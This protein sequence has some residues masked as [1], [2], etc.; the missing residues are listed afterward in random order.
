MKESGKVVETFEETRMG[1]QWRV[2]ISRPSSM[3]VAELWN[4]PLRG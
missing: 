4:I 3:R 1:G 2:E